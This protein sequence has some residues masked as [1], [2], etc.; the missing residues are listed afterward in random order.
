MQSKLYQI[1]SNIGL[2]LGGGRVSAQFELWEL[3]EL[4]PFSF[5]TFSI[6]IP[7]WSLIIALCDVRLCVCVCVRVSIHHVFIFASLLSASCI[8]YCAACMYLCHTFSLMC[9]YVFLGECACAWFYG[10]CVSHCAYLWCLLVFGSLCA[11]TGLH[12]CV[13]LSLAVYVC[14]PLCMG[15]VCVSASCESLHF[16]HYPSSSVDRGRP[17]IFKLE[18]NYWLRLWW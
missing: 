5:F 1:E 18:Y 10:V 15:L 6:L 16:P 7:S 3:G 9:V 11:A 12:V 2:A 17:S 14:L 8:S 4:S 13:C